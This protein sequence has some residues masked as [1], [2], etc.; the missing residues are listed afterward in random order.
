MTS[1]GRTHPVHWESIAWTNW[2]ENDSSP[3]TEVSVFIDGEGKGAKSCTQCV[4]LRLQDTQERQRS[5][6]RE[7]QGQTDGQTDQVNETKTE[8]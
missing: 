6:G 3:A 2:T 4:C 8:E 7:T 1:T 5:M